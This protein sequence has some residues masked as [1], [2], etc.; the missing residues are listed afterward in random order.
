M[1]ISKLDCELTDL[2]ATFK[3]NGEVSLSLRKVVVHH[4]SFLLLA[5]ISWQ[6]KTLLLL[7]TQDGHTRRI[8]CK[9]TYQRIN[10]FFHCVMA[11]AFFK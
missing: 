5:S 7:V 2:N 1:F 9:E 8:I 3:D 6:P 4:V 11:K 10:N